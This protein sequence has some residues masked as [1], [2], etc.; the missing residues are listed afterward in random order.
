MSGSC[1][2]A[3]S[4]EFDLYRAARRRE[5]LRLENIEKTQQMLEAQRSLEEKIVKNKRDAE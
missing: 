1:A 3:G 5:M 2:G 4:G